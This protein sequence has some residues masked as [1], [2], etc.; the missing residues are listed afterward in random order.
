[1][2]SKRLEKWK[3]QRA[4]LDER[5]QHIER[6][7]RDKARRRRNR[8]MIIGFGTIEA[9]LRKGNPVILRSV[10]DLAAFLKGNVSRPADRKTWGFDEAASAPIQKPPDRNKRPQKPKQVDTSGKSLPKAAQV[11]ADAVLR[12]QP[13]TIGKPLREK[14]TQDDLEKEF[15]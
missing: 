10:E 15:L 4:Q 1:M 7:E 11:S 3:Q 6:L 5:I 14:M 9:E 2:T 12:T 13:T 8:Q